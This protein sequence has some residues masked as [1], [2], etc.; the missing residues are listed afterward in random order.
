MKTINQSANTVYWGN[1]VIQQNKQHAKMIVVLDRTLL[2]IKL[3]V[4]FVKWE[5]GKILTIN[6]I[7]KVVASVHIIVKLVQLLKL[8][9][10]IVQSEDT[11]TKRSVLY[12]PIV[13]HAQKDLRAM[14]LL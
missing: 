5:N 2:L 1:T 3:I 10:Q 14:V 11:T 13:E 6:W 8:L 12:C 7:A 9:V 4:L